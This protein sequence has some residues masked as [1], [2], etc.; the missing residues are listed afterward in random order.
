MKAPEIAPFRWEPRLVMGRL[1]VA[2]VPFRPSSAGIDLRPL[3]FGCHRTLR[4]GG[5]PLLEQG[6]LDFSPAK[7]A[8]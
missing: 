5:S 3:M 4:F 7:K 6:E 1:S 2:Q 8:S